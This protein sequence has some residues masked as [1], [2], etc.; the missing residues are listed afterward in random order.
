M[1]HI[2]LTDEGGYSCQDADGAAHAQLPAV[3]CWLDVTVAQFSAVT[4]TH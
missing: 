1:K 3:N 4:Y 2:S